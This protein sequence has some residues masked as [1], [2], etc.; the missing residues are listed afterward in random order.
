MEESGVGFVSHFILFYL[1][2]IRCQ[3][4]KLGKERAGGSYV[5]VRFHI[6]SSFLEKLQCVYPQFFDV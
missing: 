6:H 5:C 4:K 1:L 3:R 2:F